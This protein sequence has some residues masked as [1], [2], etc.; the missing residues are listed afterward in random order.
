MNGLIGTKAS[1]K[2]IFVATD[3]ESNLIL[4]TIEDH[5]EAHRVL[6]EKYGHWQDEIAWK[7]LSGQITNAEAT[8]QVQ[9]LSNLGKKQSKETI[10]KR[11]KATIGQKRRCKTPE[12]IEVMR[13]NSTV[14]KHTVETINKKSKN[15]LITLPN[16]ESIE[17]L[18]LKKFCKE[19]NLSLANM[20]KVASGI[21]KHHKGFICTEKHG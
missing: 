2:F 13:K 5:A 12:E 3:D 21:R 19:N 1:A 9:R 17:I 16:G 20:S 15:W 14:R 18:N 6:Y 7:G 8:K 4:L 10:E 11:R